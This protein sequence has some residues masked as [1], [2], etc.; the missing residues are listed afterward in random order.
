VSAL[1]TAEGMFVV[2][3]AATSA[4][5]AVRRQR[6]NVLLMV[7]YLAHGEHGRDIKGV[8]QKEHTNTVRT[9]ALP[10]ECAVTLRSQVRTRIRV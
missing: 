1:E 9:R 10:R 6:H 7:G 2:A 8:P 4:S 5:H 3:A